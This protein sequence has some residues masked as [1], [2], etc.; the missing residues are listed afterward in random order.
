MY[1]KPITNG[2]FNGEDIKPVP[3]KSG[4]RQ[5]CPLSLYLVRIVLQDTARA[6]RQLT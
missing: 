5:G 4:A 2:K 1:I 3:L 6:S